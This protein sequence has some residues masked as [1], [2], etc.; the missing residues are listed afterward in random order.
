MLRVNEI[1]RQ[2]LLKCLTFNQKSLVFKTVSVPMILALFPS[3]DKKEGGAVRRGFR[4]RPP[5]AI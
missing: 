2:G 1:N 5:C 3:V 4:C